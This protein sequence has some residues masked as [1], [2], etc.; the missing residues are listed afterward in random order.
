MDDPVIVQA[1]ANPRSIYAHELELDDYTFVIDERMC[2]H[3]GRY[4]DEHGGGRVCAYPLGDGCAVIVHEPTGDD[5]TGIAIVLEPDAAA[6][7]E[8][9]TAFRHVPC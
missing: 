9:E 8:A 4:D 6:R 2:S 3:V 1:G 5:W 7:C